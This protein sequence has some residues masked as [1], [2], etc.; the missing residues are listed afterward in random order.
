MNGERKKE[1][2]LTINNGQELKNHMTEEWKNSVSEIVITE[3]CGNELKENVEFRGWVYLERI[4]VKKNAL[5]NFDVLSICDN[6]LLK[7]IEIENGGEWNNAT[8]TYRAP[9]ERVKSVVLASMM[10]DD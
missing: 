3:G 4:V 2:R 9:F 5:K 1:R 7:S 10:I 8:Q 6:P